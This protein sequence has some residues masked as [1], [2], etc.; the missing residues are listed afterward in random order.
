M[1]W[2]VPPDD[3]TPIER[4]QGILRDDIERLHEWS[5]QRQEVF[6]GLWFDNEAAEAGTG[7]VTIGLATT[8]EPDVLK[9]EVAPL[10]Q[11]PDRLVPVK[12]QW[13]YQDLRQV[14]ELI[15]QEMGGEPGQGTYIS[16]CGIDQ[17]ANVVEIGISTH[18]HQFAQ[19]LLD[20]YGRD[21]T[22]VEFGVRA[23]AL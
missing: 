12:C 19:R 11:H 13:T 8:L 1:I 18:D 4:A 3:L 16:T 6:G 23:V 9:Q 20:R 2:N 15:V 5:Q 7:A 10:M 14:Q 21:R 17:Q 22:R